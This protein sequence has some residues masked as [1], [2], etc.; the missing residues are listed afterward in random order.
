ML[1]GTVSLPSASCSSCEMTSI[2]F[3]ASHV[4][5]EDCGGTGVVQ[6]GETDETGVLRAGDESTVG[7]NTS[8]TTC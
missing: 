8:E 2:E 4:G 3:C 7:N 6:G 5:I 1:F